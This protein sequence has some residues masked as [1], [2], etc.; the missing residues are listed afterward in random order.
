M[1][2][3]AA[4]VLLTLIASAASAAGSAP[5]ARSRNG[6]DCS[7]A[8]SS[9]ALQ[10]AGRL[11]SAMRYFKYVVLAVIIA[12]TWHMGTLVFREYDPFLAFFH[13]GTGL[14]ELPYAYAI[15]GVVLI[16]SLYIERFFCKYACRS[17]PCWAFSP[18]SLDQGRARSHDC[19]AAT[20]ARRNATPTST[21]CRRQPS[22]A[23]SATT[24]WTASWTAETERPLRARPQVEVLPPGLCI[25]AGGRLFLLIGQ[26][27][28]G[29]VA[30]Q[31]GRGVFH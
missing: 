12:L 10:P 27:T 30:D 9:K 5:S 11:D 22:A 26:P 2:L 23:R 18:R 25:H 8:R 24:A 20:S 28:R 29:K 19:K 3:F 21:S 7:A 16:G 14:D 1:I 13:L 15:L 31:A 17:A 4:L 6:W